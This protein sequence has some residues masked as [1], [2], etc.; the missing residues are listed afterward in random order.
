[1]IEVAI[2]APSLNAAVNRWRDRVRGE[3]LHRV[4]DK[5]ASQSRNRALRKKAEPGGIRSSAG[6]AWR[7]RKDTS[8]RHPLL[9]KT[10]SLAGGFVYRRIDADEGEVTNTAPHF[11]FHQL[12]TI[13]T[14]R[15]AS[16]GVDFED[17]K[18]IESLIQDFVER[19]M[20]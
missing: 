5:I 3:L 2:K 11:R 1:M 15:R 4:G 19:R 10:R 16:L 9:V 6:K 20:R 18:E 17:A 7:P 14:P 12:G 13:F 8:L